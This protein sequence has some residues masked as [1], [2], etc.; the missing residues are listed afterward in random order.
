MHRGSIVK[1]RDVLQSY[2]TKLKL[3]QDVLVKTR[4]YMGAIQK[5]KAAWISRNRLKLQSLMSVIQ[6]QVQNA[7][8]KVK[9]EV[10]RPKKGGKKVQFEHPFIQAVMHLNSMVVERA[11]KELARHHMTEKDIEVL[12]W[13]QLLEQDRLS[14]LYQ[15]LD[16]KRQQWELTSA[17]G[18]RDSEM[19]HYQTEFKPDPGLSQRMAQI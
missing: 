15:K 13:H 16:E 2:F 4:E 8:A 3:Q 6:S 17:R 5:I 12:S 1:A 7:L 10:T 18:S 11:I 14:I 9:K 19:S